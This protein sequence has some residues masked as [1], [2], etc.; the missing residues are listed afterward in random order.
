MTEAFRRDNRMVSFAIHLFI[1][2]WPAGWMKTIMDC[3]RQ[4]KLAFFT[5]RDALTPLLANIRAD[6][7]AYFAGELML[8]EF[9]ICNDTHDKPKDARLR[10]QFEVDDKVVFAQQTRAQVKPCQSQFQGFLRL[11]APV[12][13]TRTTAKLRLALTRHDGSV[14]HDTAL[15]VE[16]FPSFESKPALDAVVIGDVRM[17]KQLGVRAVKSANL[18]VV[19]DVRRYAARR[20]AIDAA[21]E[22]GANVV[23]LELP[24]G[25]YQIGGTP[26]KVENCGMQSR[27]FVSRATG[28]PLVAQFQPEDFRFWFDSA[29]GRP[30]P[31]LDRLF[32]APDWTPILSTGNGD[33]GVAWQPA[34]AAAELIRG[35]GRYRICQVTLAAR[36]KTNPVAK[37]FGDA[38]LGR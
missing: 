37:L 21:V 5:Y 28:H 19:T 2:A 26:V 38:L 30:A 34:L 29:K 18:Y 22:Q 11:R 4:P 7:I 23:F 15:N 17:A 24:A 32:T 20:Q 36:I 27:H 14:V 6:R 9:W 8:F 13:T 16:L 1:D 33:W 35:A 10:Y 31:L 12:V 25:E 3:M